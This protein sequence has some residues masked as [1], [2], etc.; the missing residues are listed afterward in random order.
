MRVATENWKSL[1]VTYRS[2]LAWEIVRV[3]SAGAGIGD[4]S[5]ESSGEQFKKIPAEQIINRAFDIADAFIE[6][7]L[8]SGDI[9]YELNEA[10]VRA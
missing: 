5:G 9:V 10:E 7:E 4:I 8:V 1:K 2:Q 6:S 3:L